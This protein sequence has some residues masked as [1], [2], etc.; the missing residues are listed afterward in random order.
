M[1]APNADGAAVDV[2]KLSEQL[3]LLLLVLVVLIG[4]YSATDATHV[5]AGAIDPPRR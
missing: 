3:I 5:T 1:S 4:A 2:Y